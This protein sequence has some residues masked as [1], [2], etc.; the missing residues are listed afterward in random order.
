MKKI[1][2][3]DV[4]CVTKKARVWAMRGVQQVGQ[5]SQL[6]G[7]DNVYSRTRL[8]V[9]LL[10]HHLFHTHTHTQIDRSGVVYVNPKQPIADHS[11]LQ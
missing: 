6:A 1:R 11:D 3:R 4:S 5:N 9:L 10:R 8:T 7:W 2:E